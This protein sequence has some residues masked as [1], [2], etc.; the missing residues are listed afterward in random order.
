MKKLILFII[1]CMILMGCGSN[2]TVDRPNSTV[3]I[4]CMDVNTDTARVCNGTS[5]TLK[6]SARA[7]QS[8]ALAANWLEW[9][10]D[11][12]T[13]DKATF[14]NVIVENISTA[15]YNGVFV[16]PLFI[17]GT[18][19]MGFIMGNRQI[20]GLS[21]HTEHIGGSWSAHALEGPNVYEITFYSG[22][23]DMGTF[24]PTWNGMWTDN[25]TY[26][27]DWGVVDADMAV[28]GL[29]PITRG[30]VRYNYIP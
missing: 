14:A 20:A 15:I 1:G 26:S 10:A 11:N 30:R 8:N 19:D 13:L 23:V 17:N 9:T 29:K 18:G 6:P 21:N 12:S 2:G 3:K 5:V 25:T 24:I 28:L 16:A 22:P 27:W 4:T 7:V